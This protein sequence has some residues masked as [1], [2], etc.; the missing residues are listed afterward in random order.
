MWSWS[1]VVVVVAES[2]ILRTR[3]KQPGDGLI[4]PVTLGKVRLKLALRRTGEFFNFRVITTGHRLPKKVLCRLECPE[5]SVSV[6]AAIL[7]N[8]PAVMS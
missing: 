2:K 1:V 3:Q 6:F 5:V 4:T 7:V 8:P